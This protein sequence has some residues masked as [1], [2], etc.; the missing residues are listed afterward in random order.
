[1]RTFK[2]YIKNGSSFD[3]QIERFAVTPTSIDLWDSADNPSKGAFLSLDDTAAIVPDHQPSPGETQ[4]IHKTVEFLV[5]L[6]EHKEPIKVLAHQFDLSDSGITFFW[7][8]YWSKPQGGMELRQFPIP[9]FY[10]AVSEVVA[11]VPAGGLL[12]PSRSPW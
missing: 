3:M 6:K 8:Q 5:Y 10:F 12:P 4:A 11:I 2:V 1:M 9:D 7:Q